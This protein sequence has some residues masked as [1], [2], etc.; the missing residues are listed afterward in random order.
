MASLGPTVIL[1]DD[2]HWVDE[3]SVSLI[4]Y[5][6]RAADIERQSIALIAAS[7]PSTV[8]M[9]LSGSL[10]RLMGRERV[11][12][13]QLGPLS[14]DAA[15]HL[16]AELAPHLDDEQRVAVWKSSAG[17]PFWLELL[18]TSEHLHADVD[19]EV[20]DRRRSLSRDAE[21]LLTLLALVARPLAAGDVGAIEEWSGD[22]VN[23]STSVLTSAGLVAVDGGLLTVA[24]DLIRGAVAR[25]IDDGRA[26]SIHLRYGLWREQSGG[27]D[28][29]AIFEALEH[30]RLGGHPVTGLAARLG[31][32]PRRRL[33]GAGGLGRLAEIADDSDHSDPEAL[34]LRRDVATLAAE[35][36]EHEGRAA[37]L[38]GL[39]GV[40]PWQPDCRGTCRV[41]CFRGGGPPGASR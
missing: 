16:V 4:H 17:S 22:R 8:A 28:E 15:T 23:E 40:V 36:G 2:L 18:A 6:V 20:S 1:V 11:H 41:A 13:L 3:P 29:R 39:L 24:H 26:R 31:R 25:T 33:L 27:D 37:A 35:L 7:R 19:R 14:R 10:R 21:T 5:L 12:D 30:Q 34:A 32:S 38:V 9:S